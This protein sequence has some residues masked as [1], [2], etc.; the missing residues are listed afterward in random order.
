MQI[1][2]KTDWLTLAEAAAAA[3]RSYSWARDRA[4]VNVF[5]T[6]RDVDGKRI[7]VSADSLKEELRREVEKHGH[8][9]FTRRK[10]PRP[11]LRLIVDNTR[12]N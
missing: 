3:G 6:R 4:A 8:R 2:R 1:V 10:R 12:G 11:K 7:L 9:Q 5:D